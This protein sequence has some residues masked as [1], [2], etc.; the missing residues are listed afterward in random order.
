MSVLGSCADR[1]LC[2]VGT[3]LSGCQ[4]PAQILSRVGLRPKARPWLESGLAGF[5]LGKRKPAIAGSPQIGR[6]AERQF[7]CVGGQYFS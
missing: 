5:G 1:Q 2:G 7:L 4:Q 3:P 6:F